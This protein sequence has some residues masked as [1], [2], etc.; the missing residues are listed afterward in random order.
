MNGHALVG[1]RD[2]SET[3]ETEDDEGFRDKTTDEDSGTEDGEW[4]P[5]PRTW[6][7]PRGDET[8]LE[9]IEER[10]GSMVRLAE[11][12]DDDNCHTM[13]TIERTQLK[14]DERREWKTMRS[15]LQFI[16]IRAAKLSRYTCGFLGAQLT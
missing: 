4:C 12:T 15:G 6:R 10:V 1:Q 16:P 13:N 5:P 8:S 7:I 11:L 2:E 3:E 14:G 9:L